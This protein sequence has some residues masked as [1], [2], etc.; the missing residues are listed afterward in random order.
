MM[1]SQFMNKQPIPNSQLESTWSEKRTQDDRQEVI[2]I[3]TTSLGGELHGTVGNGVINDG[4]ISS[5]KLS[6]AVAARL[7]VPPVRA[8]IVSDLDGA[9]SGPVSSA[10][11]DGVTLTNGVRLVYPFDSDSTLNGL[12]IYNTGGPWTRTSDVI[13]AGMTFDVQRGGTVYGGRRMECRNLTNPVIGSDGIFFLAQRAAPTDAAGGDLDGS[14]PN[15]TIATN[16]V[17]AGK[18]AT[19]AVTSSKIAGGAVTTAKL[20]D[21]AVTL[22]KLSADVRARFTVPPVRA[23]VPGN[24]GGAFMGPFDSSASDDVVLND[25][26]RIAITG[27]SDE[28][29]NGL[30]VYRIA[31]LAVRTDDPITAGMGVFVLPGGTNYGGR[32]QYCSNLSDPVIGVDDIH[33]DFRVAECLTDGVTIANVNSRHS[34]IDN[35]NIQK[36]EVW[37][38]GVYIGTR[39]RI[40]FVSGGG[41]T[42]TGTDNAADDR[43]DIAVS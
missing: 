20:A 42:F 1:G 12:Y 7:T 22:P 31:G 27:E 17:T 18:I 16:A 14:Y 29:L 11:S 25:F 5:T 2:R 9:L 34:V 38:D 23:V 43:V 41:I 15:P 4:V 40:N 36:I 32:E 3:T 8:V 33:F 24:L 26:D 13:T 10:T 37:V 39:I 30:Y 19:N 21:D 28:K 35:T 6:S